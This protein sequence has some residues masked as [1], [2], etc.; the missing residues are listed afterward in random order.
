MCGAR[1]QRSIDDIVAAMTT[2]RRDPHRRDVLRSALAGAMLG[3]VPLSACAKPQASEP[4]AAAPARKKRILIL[5]GT[6]FLGP[7]TVAA[8]TARGHE[9]TIFNRG[10]REKQLPLEIK[11]EH[12]DGNRDPNRP[13]EPERGPA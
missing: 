9:I 12:L 3:A 2:S 6:G 11:G 4:K 8:A 13:A 7:K 5:G 1:W 10:R